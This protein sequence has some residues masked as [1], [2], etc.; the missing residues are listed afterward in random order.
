MNKKVEKENFL[1]ITQYAFVPILFS[2]FPVLSLY[3]KNRDILIINSIVLPIFI[4]IAACLLIYFIFYFIFKSHKKTSIFVSLFFV[5]FYSIGHLVNHIGSL[6]TVIYKITIT[7]EEFLIFIFCN[8][9]LI[10]FLHFY[11]A[12]YS[13]DVI[14]GLV[15][16]SGVT[17]FLIP[18]FL[19]LSYVFSGDV[20]FQKGKYTQIPAIEDQNEHIYGGKSPDIYYIILDGYGRED[21]LRD[22][23]NFDNSLFIE[24]LKNL[25]FYVAEQSRSNYCQTYLRISSSFNMDY[26]QKLSSS[27]VEEEGRSN[28]VNL[29]HNNAVF[30]NLKNHGYQIVSVSGTWTDENIY[31]DISMKAFAV[32]LNKFEHMLIKVTPLGFFKKFRL[33]YKRNEMLNGFKQLKA[34]AKISDPTFVY[35]HFLIP[36]PPFI[37]ASEGKPVSP[38]SLVIEHDGDHYLKYYPDLSEYRKK[39]IDQLKYLNKVVFDAIKNILDES[40]ILPVIIIQSDHGP[41]SSTRWE[42]PEKTDMKERL[43]ILNA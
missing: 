13:L 22:T 40:D 34:I 5:L 36:H 12:N 41:G 26:L 43:S 21:V 10:V 14:F 1:K 39:Y 16:I 31:S 28:A 32:D 6:Y 19:L 38:R 8:L 37:F 11:K 27:K 20:I 24:S 18:F 42:E 2:L 15:K 7:A 25:G 9:V 17:C 3:N 4:S 33:D 35:A 30:K 29:I 23:Y